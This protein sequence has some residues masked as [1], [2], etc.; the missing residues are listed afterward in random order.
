MNFLEFAQINATKLIK[1][2]LYFYKLN[3]RSFNEEKI[4]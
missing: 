1:D 4:K 3:F 2:E